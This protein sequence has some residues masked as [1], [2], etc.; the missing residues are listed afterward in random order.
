MAFDITK[1][2]GVLNG[3]RTPLTL[4]G[5]ALLVF[6]GIVSKLLDMKIYP[7]LAQSSTAALLSR[8]LEYTFVVAIVA[9]ILGVASY[10]ATQFVP[11]LRRKKA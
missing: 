4:A 9:L 11:P 6:Y 8:L 10:L 7:Q 1:I 3:I 2:A 5:L